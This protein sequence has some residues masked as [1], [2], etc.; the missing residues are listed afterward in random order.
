M[1]EK[2]AEIEKIAKTANQLEKGDTIEE[3]QEVNLD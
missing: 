3:L 1:E 2:A